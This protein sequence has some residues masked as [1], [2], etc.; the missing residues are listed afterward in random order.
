MQNTGRKMQSVKINNAMSLLQYN[1]ALSIAS[2]HIN[3]NIIL[4]Q[5]NYA[6][7]LL[8]TALEPAN[9]EPGGPEPVF[10]LTINLT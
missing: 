2:K 6:E 3:C 8:I 1:T 9:P 10:L 5:E 7:E 4:F